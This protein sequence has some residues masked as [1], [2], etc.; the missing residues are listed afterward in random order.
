MLIYEQMM[1]RLMQYKCQDA[2]LTPGVLQPSPLKRILSRDSRRKTS[3]EE[4]HVIFIPNISESIRLLRFGIKE[5]NLVKMT[6]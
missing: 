1:L 5:A 4:K 3:R 6:F 2:N